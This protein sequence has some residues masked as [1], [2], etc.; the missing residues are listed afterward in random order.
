MKRELIM[1]TGGCYC[2]AIRYRAAGRVFNST[3]CYCDM[4]R[5]TTGAPCVAWC[6]VESDTLEFLSGTPTRF[7]SSA[8]ATRTF[9]PTCGTQL[10]FVDDARPGETDITTCSLDNP[11]AVAPR[12]HTFIGEQIAWLALA[13]GLPRYRRS[14]PKASGGINATPSGPPTPAPAIPS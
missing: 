6:S 13:D 8:H 3:I 12:N 1:L 10:T 5:G 9:C 14:A 4:C 11:E 7:H 2:K